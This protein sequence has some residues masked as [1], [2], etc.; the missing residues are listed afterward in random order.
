MPPIISAS[1]AST[2]STYRPATAGVLKQRVA[3]IVGAELEPA[4]QAAG[5]E[6]L[7]EAIIEFNH[8]LYEANRVFRTQLTVTNGE[9]SLP[10]AFYK[11]LECELVGSTGDRIR[12]LDYIDWA[13]HEH[14]YGYSQQGF[15]IGGF[16]QYT[17]FNIY[18]EG[19]LRL[20]PFTG[21]TDTSY[22]K[23]SYYRR[24]PILTGDGDVLDA[25][26]EIQRALLLKAQADMLRTHNPGS[27]ALQIT[28]AL[29]EK[30][31]EE[32]LRVDSRHPDM[33][34]RFRLAPLTPRSWG[35]PGD[36]VTYIKI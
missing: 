36:L 10:A 31:W 17:L 11:E 33:K 12:Q 28:T 27:P 23:I 3:R 32:F 2:T 4:M 8:R 30:A 29:A 22:V 16:Y 25:P 9:A 26:Q 19:K 34:P 14:T 7:N 24:F 5:L 21:A 20:M 1:S 13:E 35:V 15:G 18:G 6:Y